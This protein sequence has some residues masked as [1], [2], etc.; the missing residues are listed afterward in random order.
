MCDQSFLDGYNDIV[1]WLFWRI[2]GEHHMFLTQ[3][4]K[5]NNLTL[6]LKKKVNI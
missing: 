6:L 3:K 4:P 1:E 5:L 2:G